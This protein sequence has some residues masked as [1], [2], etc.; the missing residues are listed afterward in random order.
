MSRSSFLRNGLNWAKSS[1]GRNGPMVF[2][3]EDVTNMFPDAR[4]K[5]KRADSQ[6]DSLVDHHT[7]NEHIF[8]GSPH[9]SVIAMD[10][11][12][13]TV[14]TSFVS[15][16][17]LKTE[18]PCI[19]STLL[20]P[21]AFKDLNKKAAETDCSLDIERDV[22]SLFDCVPAKPSPT[23]LPG[24][25]SKRH[26]NS[27]GIVPLSS[28]FSGPDFNNQIGSIGE[29]R[30]RKNFKERKRRQTMKDKFEELTK[31]LNKN[32]CVETES[33]AKSK[34]KMKKMEVLAEAITAI[35]DLQ[36]EVQTLKLERFRYASLLS[37]SIV[38]QSLSQSSQGINQGSLQVG[39]DRDVLPTLMD[40]VAGQQ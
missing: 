20:S 31:L 5:R 23:V 2:S 28:T 19:G 16:N 3:T 38:G 34:S 8:A 9:P 30:D 33:P 22:A 39:A 24:A 37:H 26:S 12:R 21:Y 6:K 29:R 7:L 4:K 1:G 15:G 35:K 10:E 11:L 32:K 40:A 13:I 25:S 17:D 36:E 14:P 27:T 18:L